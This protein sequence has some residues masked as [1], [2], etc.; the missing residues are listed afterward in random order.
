MGEYIHARHL[1]RRH[2]DVVPASTRAALQEWW[3]LGRSMMEWDFPQVWARLAGLKQHPA[4]FF[5]YAQ[6]VG[7]SFRRRTIPKLATVWDTPQDSLLG[8]PRQDWVV[9]LEHY[10]KEAAEKARKH[11]DGV[12]VTDII[13]FLESPSVSV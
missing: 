5:N 10:R 13:S 3:N 4:P 2:R 1:W 6:E 7:D 12:A 11:T 9:F 8:L